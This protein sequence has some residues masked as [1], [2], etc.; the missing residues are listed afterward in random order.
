MGGG[1]GVTSLPCV[2]R[3]HCTDSWSYLKYC[4]RRKT[5]KKKKKK[6]KHNYPHRV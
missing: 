5:N 2:D 3:I 4:I 1:G 6:K